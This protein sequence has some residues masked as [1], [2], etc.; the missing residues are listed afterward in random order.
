MPSTFRKHRYQVIAATSIVLFAGLACTLLATV[1]T[2]KAIKSQASLRFD[3]ITDSLAAET[4]RRVN[5]PIYGLKG[6]RGVYASSEKVTRAEFAAYVASRDLPSEFPGAVGFGFIERVEA[7]KLPAF[8]QSE[9]ADEAPEFSIR[10][11]SAGHAS[12]ICTDHLIIKHI[13]PLDRNAEAWGLD[14]GQDLHRRA[15]AEDAI[16]S[17]EPRIT[18]RVSLVQDPKSRC[19]FLYFLP[20]YRNGVEIKT[21]EQRAK[22]LVG[23]LYCPIVLEEAMAGVVESEVDFL[24]LEIY[25]GANVGG[26]SRLYDYDGHLNHV[27]GPLPAG[28]YSGRMFVAQRTVD[29]GGRQWTLRTSSTPVFEGNISFAPAIVVAAAGITVSLFS[30]AIVW[31]LSRSRSRAESMAKSITAELRA[32]ELRIREASLEAERLAEIARR[33]SNAVVITD[34]LGRVEWVNEGFTRITGYTLDDAKGRTPGSFLQGPNS[35]K[36]VAGALKEAIQK[37]KPTSVEIIN[38]AKDRREYWI[39]IDIAPL[40]DA[41]G[42]LTGFMAIES[43]ITE[44]KSSSERAEAA[45]RAKSEFLANMSHEIRTPLTSILGCCDILR[46]DGRIEDAP[47]RR[48]QTIET[49]RKAGDH[50]LTVINDILDLSKIEAGK[51]HTALVETSLP[52]V[53]RE[54]LD[55]LGPRVAEKGIALTCRLETPISDII[56]SDPTHL[57]QIILNLA[58]NS[59]KFTEAGSIDLI[60]RQGAYG[61]AYG[62]ETIIEIDVTDSGPGMTQE[63]A[64]SLFRPFTQADAS[65]TR[66]YGGTGLGLTISR[67]LAEFLGGSVSLKCTELGVGSTFTL[68]FPLVA[69]ANSQ[70]TN[71]I[72]SERDVPKTVEPRGRLHGSVLVAEDSPDIQRIL[73]FHL[74]RAGL[75]VTTADNGLE[76]LQLIRQEPV[77]GHGFDLLVTDMQMPEMDGYS[78]ASTLRQEGFVRPII[79]LTAH[80][81]AEDK[82]RCLA[83]GCNGYVT[84]PIVKSELLQA[85]E[86]WLTIKAI[87]TSNP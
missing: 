72:A 78:L 28:S 26:G 62:D 48:L 66:K 25:D 44:L 2:S 29:I 59:A 42:V 53:L 69:A 17:G 43:D 22:A 38:Y 76:A 79:A 13:Y 40:H 27:L 56:I 86:E 68:K 82:V 67:R 14:I 63:Q 70:M 65:L 87:E 51:F 10:H 73:K 24:D 74:G 34:V 50:L 21:P 47:P 15:V 81:M 7:E 30:G 75:R 83:T 35:D 57:R 1:I 37:E 23:L 39:S 55:I 5:Q 46:E 36:V 41:E 49:I 6:A 52:S 31:S 80:A 18:G 32:S 8:L 3:R 77:S 64:S 61:D 11:F 84:K 60:I 20:V 12:D 45:N 16:R 33:T 4:R 58:G 71:V 54:V 19:G 85:C 9:R